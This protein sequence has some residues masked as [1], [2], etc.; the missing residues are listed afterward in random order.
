MLAQNLTK[1]YPIFTPTELAQF[2]EQ[3]QVLNTSIIEFSSS[4]PT[5]KEEF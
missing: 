2:S 3:F 5:I 4:N 1:I